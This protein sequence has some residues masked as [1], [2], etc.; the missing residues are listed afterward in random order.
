MDFYSAER[1]QVLALQKL[2]SCCGEPLRIDIGVLIFVGK[3]GGQVG[4]LCSAFTHFQTL[5]LGVEQLCGDDWDSLV[6]NLQIFNYFVEQGQHDDHEHIQVLLLDFQ[7]ILLLH[8]PN[9]DV[10]VLGNLFSETIHYSDAFDIQ[11]V[12]IDAINFLELLQVAEFIAMHLP[13]S[14]ENVE[15]NDSRIW[16]CAANMLGKCVNLA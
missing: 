11:H 5:Q 9:I 6:P 15:S 8:L 14:S 7:K 3:E 16:L 4:H 12:E 13:R 10:L 1:L 2:T